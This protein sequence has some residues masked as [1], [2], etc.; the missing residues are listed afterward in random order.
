MGGNYFVNYKF[1]FD[2]PGAGA[3]TC[4]FSTNAGGGYPAT[5]VHLPATSSFTQNGDSDAEVVSIIGNNCLSLDGFFRT[6]DTAALLVNNQ[7]SC[8][9]VLDSGFGT[10]T[11][12]FLGAGVYATLQSCMAGA[13]LK[14][15]FTA[16]TAINHVI[17]LCTLIPLNNF[18]T[19]Y[20]P[21]IS[22]DGG[23]GNGLWV[24]GQ[25]AAIPKTT[26]M[27]ASLI[28]NPYAPKLF[29][30]MQDYGVINC[31][32][33][34]ATQFYCGT[35]WNNPENSWSGTGGANDFSNLFDIA[36]A[37]IPLL[38]K[39]GYAID[40]IYPVMNIFGVCAPQRQS[41]RSANQSM[42]VKRDSDSTVQTI[43]F[44][45]DP[46]GLLDTASIASFCLGTIG[47]VSTYYTQAA[48][49]TAI[50]FTSAGANAPIVYQSGA[51]KT[52]NSQPAMA[53][54]GSTNYFKAIG[55]SAQ[56][57]NNNMY[58]A[59][60]IQI[61]DYAANYGIFGS[62][63]ANGLELRVDQTTGFVRLLKNGGATIVVTSYQIPVNAP[64]LVSGYYNADGSYSLWLNG[65]NTVQ[66]TGTLVSVTQG[67]VQVGAGGP[68]G[69]ELL[70]GF[71]CGWI[72]C[73][74]ITNPIS[75]PQFGVES[76]LK[77]YWG[78]L[79]AIA[80]NSTTLDPAHT[81]A[82]LTLSNGNLTVTDVGGGSFRNS[83][84]TIPKS[85]GKFYDEVTVTATSTSEVIGLANN[86]L[87]SGGSYPGS[88][89]NSVGWIVDGRVLMNGATV[90]TIA[91][92]TTGSILARAVDLTNGKIWFGI[93]SGSAITWNNDILAN[94]NPA[95]NT[96]G[97]SLSTLNAG[98]YY[99]VLS[100]ASFGSI[101]TENFG[102]TAYSNITLVPSGFGNWQ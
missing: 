47:R 16:Q 52:V 46:Q 95:T 1:P 61:P 45:P 54:D 20:P 28:G 4:T 82:S 43:G 72:I 87:S 102:G 27:P 92:W 17:A 78:P 10:T 56:W 80:F 60:V 57:P 79:G 3:P 67:D 64:V 18:G 29:K 90:V 91:T 74:N 37:C 99:P 63:S 33:G 12:A 7:G 13:L 42:Q 40:G 5:T 97:I 85:T 6:S 38:Q 15:E 44:G 55:S 11:P 53:F 86:S 24:E 77:N 31:D 73:A 98:P 71:L 36:V 94:Q 75:N 65:V 100:S 19:A 96:G 39:V 69:T 22:N 21:A 88:D 101:L 89:L 50:H 26:T 34:G 41:L 68:A 23:S 9:I 66:G 93:I 48:T 76:Y 35:S 59:A 58:F 8:D 81:A 83:F 2:M 51:L 25:L 62:A 30:A 49:L 32:V 14:E 70:K 84:G